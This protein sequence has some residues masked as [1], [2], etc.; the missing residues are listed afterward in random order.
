LTNGNGNGE[1]K[2]IVDLRQAYKNDVTQAEAALRAK[3]DEELATAKKE[4][5]DKY[6]EKVV[7]W[8]YSNGFNGHGTVPPAPPPV[9]EPE[10]VAEFPQ[11]SQAPEPEPTP[12]Q[13]ETA[14]A[15]AT[16]SE[17]G[18]SLVPEANYCSQCSA[19]VALQR[20]PSAGRLVSS[21]VSDRRL[22]DWARTRKR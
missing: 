5:K 22:N 14:P 11:T 20:V 17:C 10:P 13:E 16:C 3:F 6:L 21:P 18:A 7:D 15:A 2:K 19:P 1:T 8:F 9:P 12:P 4:L